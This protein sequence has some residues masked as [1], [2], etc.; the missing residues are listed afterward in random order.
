MSKII[1]LIIVV[2]VAVG[3]GWFIYNDASQNTET[4]FGDFISEYNADD[5]TDVS[6]N[7]TGYNIEILP[8][9]D[10]DEPS[11]PLP[12]LN[13][14]LQFPQDFPDDARD[15][16]KVRIEKLNEELASDPTSFDNWLNLAI[17]R[18]IIDDFEGARDIWEYLN[19]MFPGNSISFRNLGDLYH[20][21]LKDYPKSEQNFRKAIENKPDQLS[22]YINLHELYKYSYKRDTNLAI[23]VLFDGLKIDSTSTDILIA[24]AIYYKEEKNDVENAKKYYEQ[25]RDEA[26]K[27]GNTQLVGLIDGELNALSD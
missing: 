21:Y 7:D 15:I 9:D 18:K 22:Y 20:F 24:L 17:Q 5:N 16:V 26:Q 8:I 25:A 6:E 4:D 2:A 11:I 23:E 27:A 3:A 1:G 10:I 12:E 19:T 14:S 13:Q